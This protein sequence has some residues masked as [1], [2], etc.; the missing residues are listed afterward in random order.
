MFS[1]MVARSFCLGDGDGD[2]RRKEDEARLRE[3]AMIMGH[4][5]NFHRR[6]NSIDGVLMGTGRVI[7]KMIDMEETSQKVTKH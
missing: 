4:P 1:R 7:H 5:L 3:R 6:C 2:E